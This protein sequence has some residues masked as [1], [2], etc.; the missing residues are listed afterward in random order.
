MSKRQVPVMVN[1]SFEES[2]IRVAEG[3]AKSFKRDLYPVLLQFAL[4]DDEHVQKYLKCD[5]MEDIFLDAL[6]ENKQSVMALE[7][8]AFVEKQK[9][10]K[11]QEDVWG[12]MRDPESRA[13]SPMENGFIFRKIPGSDYTYNEYVLKGISVKNLEFVID[14]TVYANIATVIPSDEQKACFEMIAEIC[15]TFNKWNATRKTVKNFPG[16]F[17]MKNGIFYPN[18]NKILNLEWLRPK[19]KS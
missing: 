6:S 11:E 19:G 4:L 18:L 9:P 7:Q 14:K 1:C 5:T 17:R 10:E 13:K 8:K 15:D 12:F 2:L 3:R 16:F